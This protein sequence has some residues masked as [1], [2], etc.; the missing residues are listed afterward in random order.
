[1]GRIIAVIGGDE[2]QI[3]LARLL[4]EDGW[5]VLTWGLEKKDPAF[6]VPLDRISEAEFVVLPLP[7]CRG[8]L[9][10]SPLTDTELPVSELWKRLSSHQ[11]IFGGM[12]A[13]LKES[14][15]DTYGLDLLDYYDREEVQIANAVPTAEGAIQYAM[16]AV[17]HTLHGSSCLVVGYGRIGKLLAHRLQ[18]LGA[19]VSVAARK[20][21]DLAWVRAYSLTPIPINQLSHELQKFDLIFNT[22]PAKVLDTECLQRIRESC[23][24]FELASKPGGFDEEDVKEYGLREIDARGLPAKVAPKSAACVIRD[25]MYQILKERGAL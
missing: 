2:R 20:L 5:S 18:W 25:S 23:V 9:L 4:K 22:V 14:L 12:T 21:S 6:S 11:I 3:H 24:L 8:D 17:G 1:M 16:Q 19:D 10:N 15:K 13:G 7:V